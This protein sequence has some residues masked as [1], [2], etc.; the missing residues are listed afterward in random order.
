MEWKNLK[1]KRSMWID[2]IFAEKYLIEVE[3]HKK[4]PNSTNDYF[5]FLHDK[6][7]HSKQT[8]N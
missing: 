6:F 2:R 8:L 4:K 7:K 3:L 1:G 5:T